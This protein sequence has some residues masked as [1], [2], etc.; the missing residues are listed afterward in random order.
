MP[1]QSRLTGQDPK[2][3]WHDPEG[4]ARRDPGTLVKPFYNTP[5]CEIP[6]SFVL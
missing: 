3:P 2:N 5:H 4:Q 1:S 6:M